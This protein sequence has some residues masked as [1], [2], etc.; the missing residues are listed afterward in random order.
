MIAIGL[1]AASLLLA[2]IPALVFLGNAARYQTPDLPVI[3]G[4]LP[5]ISVLIPA[6]NEEEGIGQAVEAALASK[7]VSLEVVVL[8]DHSEDGTA[9]VVQAIAHRDARVRLEAAP[10]LPAG[11]C[12]KQ[13]ACH[14]LAGHAR[15]SLL[16]FLDA[17]VR[18][19]PEGLARLAGF[20][21]SSD[22][23]LVSGVPLQRTGTFMEK[24]LIPLI[25]FVLLGFLPMGRMRRSSHPAYAAGCGQLFLA[26]REAYQAM[27]GHSVIRSTLHDGVKLPRAFRTA[28]HKTDLCDATKLAECRMYRGAGEV[29][30]GLAKNATEG[31]GS[32]GMIVPITGVL[33]VGQVVPFGLLA[34]SAWISTPAMLLALLAVGFAYLPRWLGVRRFGQSPLGALL[35]PLG[36]LILLF[37]QWYALGRKLLGRPAT[38][39]GRIYQPVRT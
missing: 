16:A 24:L 33:L 28:G 13:H 31:L 25:H 37:I 32:P 1:A 12:G 17:D 29:W 5:R 36:I 30:R 19:A 8:D 18:L 10:P 15:H 26:R 9:K 27:G 14:V 20:L 21:R 35:H 7:D 3:E 38:W 2:L 11:W 4:E 23:E 22:S 39:R 34:A 6:R